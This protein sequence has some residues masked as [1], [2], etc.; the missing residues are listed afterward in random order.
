MGQEGAEKASWAFGPGE[1]LAGKYRI[2]RELGTGG[3]G[4]VVAAKHL[5]LDQMV[6]LKFIRPGALEGDEAVRRFL[7][8][9]RAAARLKSEHIA[10]VLDV[11]TLDTGEPYM[12]MEYLEGVDLGQM[13]RRQGPMPISSAVGLVLQACEAIAEAHA[14]G[15][16]HRDLKPANLF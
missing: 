1:T 12:V 7:R 6:A 5:V 11:S 3:M 8:E 13:L 9:A 4:R 16:V 10:R 15:I 2:E 14:L